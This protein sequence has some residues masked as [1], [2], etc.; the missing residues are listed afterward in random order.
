[1][2]IDYLLS[3]GDATAGSDFQG[4]TNGTLNWADGDADSKWIEFAIVGDASSEGGEFFEL[5]LSNPTGAALGN[6]SVLRINIADG[7][8]QIPSP[9]G[10]GS[11]GWLLVILL[12]AALLERMLL[13]NRLRAVGPGRNN[14]DG[15]AR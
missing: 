14:R 11:F 4:A 7:P 12:S 1:M 2:S 6:Q 13:D 5:S 15:N 9:G 8:A 10:G 3:G